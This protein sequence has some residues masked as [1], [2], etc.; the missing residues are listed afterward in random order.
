MLVADERAALDTL[1]LCLPRLTD[2]TQATDAHRRKYGI[3]P[4]QTHGRDGYV[5]RVPRRSVNGARLPWVLVAVFAGI[6]ALLAVLAVRYNPFLFAFAAIFGGASYL[7]WYHA[8]GRM[9]CAARQRART[10]ARREGTE[11]RRRGRRRGRRRAPRTTGRPSPRTAYRTLD[12]DPDASDAEIQ[13]AYREKVKAV[14][15]DREGGSEAEFKQ[16][17]EAYERLSD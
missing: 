1:V 13:E 3:Q 11:Q 7:L 5:P 8:S 16:V 14:H 6:A 2:L 15:P 17:K 10:R 9:A 12:L 4:F